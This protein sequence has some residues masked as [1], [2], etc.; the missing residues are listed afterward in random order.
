[1]EQEI[2]QDAEGL[3]FRP[4]TLE[5]IPA[6]MVIE[7]DAFTL[8]WTEEAFRNELTHNHFARYMMM[9]WD[10][11]PVGYA[12]MWTV[13]DEAHVTNIAVLSPYRGRKW[14]ERL[15]LELMKTA[16]QLG[17]KRMTL[18]VRVSNRVAQNLYM[19]MGFE[20]AGLRKGYYSDNQEDA[21][22]MWAELFP[23]RSQ[24][25]RG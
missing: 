21:M 24:N 23:D 1:M 19:K 3:T 2:K 20:P 25:A 8:P 12:G 18:E 15:L 16:S 13:I 4:M 10:G 5:D 11:E 7:H 14:G 9:E 17:M 22:I 6:V